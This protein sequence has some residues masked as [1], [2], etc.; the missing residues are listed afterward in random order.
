MVSYQALYMFLFS[1]NNVTHYITLYV[2][3]GTLTHINAHLIVALIHFQPKHAYV[4]R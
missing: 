3:I 2:V 4:L 1:T